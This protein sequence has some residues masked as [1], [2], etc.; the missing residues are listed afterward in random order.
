MRVANIAL[1]LLALAPSIS[2]AIPVFDIENVTC[3]GSLTSD[4]A[5]V[6][7]MNCTGDFSLVGGTVSAD[8][9]VLFSSFGAFTLDNLSIT[10]PEIALVA[11]SLLSLGP[12]VTLDAPG[13]SITLEAS[14]LNI[15]EGAD[16]TASAT[17]STGDG[18]ITNMR[19]PGGVLTVGDA[20]S[21]VIGD[22]AIITLAV[23]EAN[24]L[25]LMLA[26]L[27]AFGGIFRARRRQF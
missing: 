2:H 18:S 9:K 13:G 17:I 16:I 8:S 24:T 11:D 21:S 4:I 27:I 23:P 10:A 19:D 12:G 26:G 3:S 14:P 1:V 20:T 7:T 5:D 15:D 22:P 25:A 6:I